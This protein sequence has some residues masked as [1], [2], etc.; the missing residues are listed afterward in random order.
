[1]WAADIRARVS[2]GSFRPVVFALI[3]ARVSAECDR[4]RKEPPSLPTAARA[5]EILARVS[6]DTGRPVEWWIA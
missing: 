1:L 4:P 5:A 2:A 3:A 6:G